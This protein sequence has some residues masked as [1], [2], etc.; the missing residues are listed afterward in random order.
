MAL[1]AF[2]E[3]KTFKKSIN[4]TQNIDELLAAYSTSVVQ[5]DSSPESQPKM[6]EVIAENLWNRC[7]IYFETELQLYHEWL[8]ANLDTSEQ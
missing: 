6:M 4:F 8:R 5:A 7:L 2:D 3:F 1:P